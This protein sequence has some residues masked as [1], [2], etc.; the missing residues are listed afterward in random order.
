MERRR[1]LAVLGGFRRAVP[2]VAQAQS[3]AMPWIGYLGSEAAGHCQPRLRA[4]HEGLRE[5]GFEEGRMRASRSYGFVRGAL[6]DERPYR[7]KRYRPLFRGFS[8]GIIASSP[9]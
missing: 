8:L 9:S 5:L 2:Q 6:S 1:F 7:V 3:Q 4:F